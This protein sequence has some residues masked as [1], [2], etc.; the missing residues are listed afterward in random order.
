MITWPQSYR[1]FFHFNFETELFFYF[2]YS[3]AMATCPLSICEGEVIRMD[4]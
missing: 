1:S 2:N 3:K 4:A